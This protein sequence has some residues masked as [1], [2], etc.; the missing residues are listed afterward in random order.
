MT[1]IIFRLLRAVLPK[2]GV[3]LRTG[4]EVTAE[5]VKKKSPTWWW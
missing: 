5:L 3:E 1:S 4:V 2:Y